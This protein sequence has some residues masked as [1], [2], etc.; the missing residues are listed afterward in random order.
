MKYPKASIKKTVLYIKY[1]NKFVVL[2]LYHKLS[3]NQQLFA[4]MAFRHA[5]TFLYKLL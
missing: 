4:R 5:Q 1:N 2:L 3:I